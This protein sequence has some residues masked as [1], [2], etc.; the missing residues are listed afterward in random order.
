MKVVFYYHIPVFI[1]N[2]RIKTPSYLGV[3]IDALAKQVDRSNN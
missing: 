2:G 1:D 3:F